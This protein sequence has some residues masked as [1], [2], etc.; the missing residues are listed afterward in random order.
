MLRVSVK[1]LDPWTSIKF[2]NGFII[3]IFLILFIYGCGGGGSGSTASSDSVHG[4]FLDS[5]VAGV[6]YETETHSGT[7]NADGTFFY[8][9]GEMIRFSLGGV[10]MGQASASPFMTPIDIVPGASNS[11]HP[12]VTNM[13]RFMQTLDIDRNP[14]NGILITEQARAELQGRG[15][16]FNMGIQEFEHDPDVVMYFDTLNAMNMFGGHRDMVPV[17]E[18]RGHMDETLRGDDHGHGGSPRG[19]M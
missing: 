9:Q 11:S 3:S 1:N 6:S 18:A 14:D 10:F 19:P 8:M 5:P 4:V 16:N 12:T 17:S 2:A 15:I 13:I 7:T